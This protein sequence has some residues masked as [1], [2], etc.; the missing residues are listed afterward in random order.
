MQMKIPALL[1]GP[2]DWDPALLPISEYETR[3]AAVRQVLM[4]EGIT[5]LV[6]HGNAMEFGALAYLTGFVPKLGPALAIVSQKDPVRLMVSGS[7]TMLSAAR[8]L[9]WVQDLGGISSLSKL[10]P[11]WLNKTARAQATKI[12]LWGQQRMNLRLYSALEAA[13]DPFGPLVELGGRLDRLRIHKSQRELQMLGEAA[14]IL[15]IASRA[16][17]NAAASRSPVRSNVLAAERAAYR[18]GAQEI[19]VL[20]SSTDGATP[21]AFDALSDRVLNLVLA[22][23]GVRFGGYWAQGFITHATGGESFVSARRSLAAVLGAAKEGVNFAELRSSAN[24][25]VYPCRIHPLVENTIG[26]SIGS[27]PEEFPDSDSEGFHH[28]RQGG[29]YM[30][31]AGA[32]GEGTDQAILSAMIAVKRTGTE[33]LWASPNFLDPTP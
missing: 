12:A 17:L 5:V 7:S 27:S 25:H 9:T 2:Y 16:F 30:L 8:K 26:H 19:R 24:S 18:S 6:V 29:V 15:D 4:E 13:I 31:H 21:V 1:T 23:I 14:R 22:Y 33:L 3:V 20:A 28:L 10:L 32:A 11:E